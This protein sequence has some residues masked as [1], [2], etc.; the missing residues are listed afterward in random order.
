[1]LE[2]VY[3]TLV[4]PCDIMANIQPQD[5]QH[6]PQWIKQ[7]SEWRLNMVL[8]TYFHIQ[9]ALRHLEGVGVKRW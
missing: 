1:M 3:V 8:P 6:K 4:F 5:V 9:I 2:V 7:T